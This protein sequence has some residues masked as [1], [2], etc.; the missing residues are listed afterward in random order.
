[1]STESTCGQG[2]AAHS[3]CVECL[4]E[5]ALGIADVLD[6]HQRALDLTDEAAC[7]E[8]HTYVTLALE[9]RA[10]A[11]QIAQSARRMAAARDLPMGRHDVAV[12]GG[13]DARAALSRLVHAE[14]AL[15]GRLVTQAGQHERLLAAMP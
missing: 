15:Q 4:A 5:V 11:V 1:M 13:V 14:R 6:H 8:H 9:L 10:V 2:L 3:D 7:A 12:M